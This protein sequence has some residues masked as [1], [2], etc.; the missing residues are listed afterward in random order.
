[1]NQHVS[2]AAPKFLVVDD[3][4]SVLSGTV[5]ILK[6]QYPDAEIH[7]VQTAQAADQ[8]IRQGQPDLLVTDLSIPQ[9]AGDVAKTDT[10]IKLLET[11]MQRYPTLNIVVQSANV[12]ALVLLKLAISNHGGGFTIADKNLPLQKMLEL[13]DWALKGINYTPKEMRTKNLELKHEWLQVVQLAWDERLQ[14]Q[15]IAE[16]LI[17]TESTV[18]NYWRKLQD[19]LEVYPQEGKNMRIETIQQARQKGLL[20]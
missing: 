3:H 2:K 15:A 4:E 8:W 19:A 10:G 5:E 11:L 13:V 1:M 14:D 12:K 6:R 20:D 18:R 7:T 17:C 16:R 9:V